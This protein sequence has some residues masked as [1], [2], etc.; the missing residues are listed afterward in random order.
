MS[1]DVHF[2]RCEYD[3]LHKFEWPV[4]LVDNLIWLDVN[5]LRK[6][7]FDLPENLTTQKFDSGL[8]HIVSLDQEKLKIYT[9]QTSLTDYNF[10]KYQTLHAALHHDYHMI[11]EQFMFQHLPY[12]LS[13]HPL[14]LISIFDIDEYWQQLKCIE[15]KRKYFLFRMKIVTVQF[16][17]WKRE[18]KSN[19][20]FTPEKCKIINS[21]VD[22]INLNLAN[23]P[24][25]GRLD[26]IYVLINF[27]RMLRGSIG[28]LES[29]LDWK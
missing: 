23:L 28:I 14:K 12:Y 7:N 9:Q 11:L 21:L 4:L 8:E 2:F 16:E 13:T 5:C 1:D 25:D 27:N 6:Q 26:K 22:N 19:S 3:D 29:L 18:K 17:H 10:C 20:L 15:N 24:N